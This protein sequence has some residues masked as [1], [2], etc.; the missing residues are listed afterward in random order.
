[1]FCWWWFKSR[2][3]RNHIGPFPER[4]LRGTGD[5]KF[6]GRACRIPSE[7]YPHADSSCFYIPNHIGNSP[8]SPLQME[9]YT[10]QKIHKGGHLS[11]DAFSKISVPEDRDER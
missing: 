3:M 4:C 2:I 8:M 7:F 11:I 5:A 9:K 6:T 10:T 1:M